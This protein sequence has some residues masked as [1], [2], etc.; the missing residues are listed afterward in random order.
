MTRESA[1]APQCWASLRRPDARPRDG[2]AAMRCAAC[3]R[4]NRDAAR[5][6]ARVA[7]LYNVQRRSWVRACL[8]SR[9]WLHRAPCLAPGGSG[10]A[11]HPRRAV[12]LNAY[13][14]AALSPSKA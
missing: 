9:S 3:S 6:S 8:E 11:V 14:A 2:V 12:A 1:A 5:L 4:A 7:P 10:V 13:A